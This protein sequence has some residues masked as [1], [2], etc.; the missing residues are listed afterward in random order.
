M[1][2]SEATDLA[3]KLMT[4]HSLFERGWRFEYDFAKRRFGQCNYKTRTIK[5]SAELTIRNSAEQVRDTI[6]HEIAHAL[7][8][9]AKHGERWRAKAAE[10]GCTAERC[11]SSKTVVTPEPKIIYVCPNCGLQYK[12]LR[13]S[14]RMDRSACLLCCNNYNNGRFSEQF[15]FQ[16]K[17]NP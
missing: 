1:D 14:A 15:R 8:P 12:R 10:I 9:G 16:T 11:Y 7:T 2:L 17:P 3:V 4:Q 5:L 13:R 6:L